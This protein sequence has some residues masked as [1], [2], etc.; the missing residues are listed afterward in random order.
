M[1]DDY[2]HEICNRM[3]KESVIEWSRY[4]TE[5]EELSFIANGGFGQV[6]QAR[7]KLDGGIYAIKKIY[8]RYTVHI[9]CSNALAHVFVENI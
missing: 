5:F 1:Y 7:H 6:Y 9:F 2:R 4:A 8:L 3:V